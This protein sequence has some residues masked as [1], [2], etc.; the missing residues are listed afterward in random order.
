MENKL[1]ELTDKLYNEGLSKGKKEAEELKK[2]A[3]ETSAQMIADAKAKAAEI[4]ENATKESEELKS[5]TEN[6]VKMA[7]SQAFSAFKQQVESAIVAKAVKAE[8]SNALGDKEFLQS[9]IK[10]VIEAYNP[11]NSDSMEL[12]LILPAAKQQELEDFV[13]KQIAGISKAPVNVNFSKKFQS[14]FKIGPKDNGYI[15]SFTDEDFYTLIGEYL[16]PKTKKIL[17]GE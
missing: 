1:Q 13:G 3:Q 6:D 2:K 15:V 10:T 16:R 7:F 4:I 14:G 17:F 11:N 8:T 9:V 12:N 5:K